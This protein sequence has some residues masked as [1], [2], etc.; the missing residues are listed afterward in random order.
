MGGFMFPDN[1][2]PVPI[3]PAQQPAAAGAV[4]PLSRR[5]TQPP[6]G[7]PLPLTKKSSTEKVAEKVE[8][9]AKII[10]LEE[11]QTVSNMVHHAKDFL[12]YKTSNELR[13]ILLNIDKLVISVKDGHF[14]YR[15]KDN[16]ANEKDISDAT[17]KEMTELE[18]KWTN[19][20]VAFLLYSPT[21]KSCARMVG[22]K[23]NEKDAGKQGVEKELSVG[24]NEALGKFLIKAHTP[25]YG[26]YTIKYCSA[27]DGV[28]KEEVLR[29][30][31]ILLTKGSKYYSSDK[32]LG[33]LLSWEIYPFQKGWVDTGCTTLEDYIKKHP[34]LD[35]NKMIS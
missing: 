33:N 12:K 31:E 7:M 17:I 3:P 21:R 13:E 26:W 24:T 16:P 18:N 30:N 34:E 14:A 2:S 23:L 29:F 20:K 5:S 28:Y 11:K 15:D 22:V 4:S 32:P 19:F 9:Q 1:T 35:I 8:K 10:T 27:K 6:G 25:Q